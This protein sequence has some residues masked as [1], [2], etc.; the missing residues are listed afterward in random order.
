MKRHHYSLPAKGLTWT[1]A[2]ATAFSSVP[3]VPV[4][5]EKGTPSVFI[6][7][8]FPEYKKLADGTYADEEIK[9]N[10]ANLKAEVGTE[11]SDLRLPES[12]TLNGYLEAEGPEFPTEYE[13][14]N[15]DWKLK[16][17]AYKFYSTDLPAGSY[18]FV[19]DLEPYT[20]PDVA[21]GHVLF[22]E[23]RLSEN[24]HLPELSVVLEDAAAEIPPETSAP[25]ETEF[26]EPTDMPVE[27]ELIQ[28]TDATVETEF[29]EQ[30]DA[31]IETELI[32]QT[33][34]AIE[35]ELIEQTD[36]AI[37]TEFTTESSDPMIPDATGDGTIVDTEPMTEPSDNADSDGNIIIDTENSNDGNT[38]DE[39][40]FDNIDDSILG[41]DPDGTVTL[42]S[43]QTSEEMITE[44]ITETTAPSEQTSE[45]TTTEVTT[46]TTAPLGVDITVS[47][48]IK[49]L[50]GGT[51]ILYADESGATEILLKAAPGENDN[52][53]NFELP[54]NYPLKDLVLTLTNTVTTEILTVTEPAGNL[55]FSDGAAKTIVLTDAAGNNYTLKLT[56]KNKEHSLTEATCTTPATC[57]VCGY[58]D[59]VTKEHTFAPATC[60]TP[61]TCTVCGATEGG[62]IAHNFTPATCIKLATCTVCGLQ[63]GEYANHT[64]TQK[65]TCTEPEVCNVCNQIISP[66]LGHDWKKATCTTPKTCKRC[67]ATEGKALGH[68]LSDDWLIEKESTDSEH[69]I[70]IRYCSRKACDYSETRPRNIIG[71]AERNVINNI[72]EGTNYK[73]KTAISFTASGSGMANAKPLD[74]DVRF[75]PS[76]WK[77]QNTPGEF[78]DNYSGAFSVSIAGNYTLT[79]NFQK[80]V[81]QGGEW[82]NTDT[83]DSKAV[84]F[85]VG[86][87][88]Q[89][90]PVNGSEEGI[91]INPQTGDTSPIIPLIILLVV[92]IVAI[93]GVVIYQKKRK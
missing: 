71:A 28:Q 62:T 34:T 76:S 59:G 89:G 39:N 30:T 42:P 84:N 27:T 48:L 81:Y 41:E 37:E 55:D 58:T 83:I 86:Q 38:D 79:V 9:K 67:G 64:S 54:C 52:T 51:E 12:I 21:D 69:G 61:Q 23:I 66:A 13:L 10:Y 87:I 32:E 90:K 6:V 46:E 3:S 53:V 22:D 82:K 33:D 75:V 18:T 92:A 74:G 1:L 85:S 63:T 19:P 65:A 8:E 56:L 40:I 77:V 26:T 80:Q 14:L 49:E 31:A 57:T 15:L 47:L 73:L 44:A 91:R 2:V 43:E 29:I 78:K 70:D 5:A 25:A 11:Q 93:V 45:E 17:G 50:T 4:H 60:T 35:T 68:D 36:A 72:T 20:S 24:I 16:P 88:I 7:T